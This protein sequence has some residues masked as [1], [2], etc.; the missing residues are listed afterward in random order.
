[1]KTLYKYRPIDKYTIRTLALGE[2]YFSSPYDF[3]DPFDSQISFPFSAT[4]DNI[5]DFFFSLSQEIGLKLSRESIESFVQNLEKGGNLDYVSEFAVQFL[6]SRHKQE[7]KDIGIY[8]LS[9]VNNNVLMYSHYCDGHKGIC[10]ELKFTKANELY[11]YLYGVSYHAKFPEINHFERDYNK[12]F[13]ER[14]TSKAINWAY[15]KEWRI[16]LPKH[17]S[18]SIVLPDNVISAVI[19]GCNTNED[20]KT[21]IKN[22]V[23]GKNSSI[24]FYNAVKSSSGY[25]LNIIKDE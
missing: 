16:I 22:I 4:K 23:R 25:L 14:Y 7:L 12:V 18:Q 10:I 21:L 19:F 15:E 24:Q 17:Q 11:N 9:E 13:R 6:K 5:V 3:N 2:I 20:D 1:M 8:C